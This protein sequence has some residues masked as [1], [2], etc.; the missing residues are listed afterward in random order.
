[1]DQRKVILG[2]LLFSV[3]S[4]YGQNKQPSLIEI[5]K[6]FIGKPYRGQ[7]LSLGNPEQ[8]ITSQEA[9]DCVTFLEHCLATRIAAGDSNA[10]IPALKHVRYAD[11]SVK[12]ENRYHYFSDAMWHLEY[13]LIQDPLHHATVA[14]DFSFLSNYWR[15]QKASSV[16]INLLAQ[17]EAELR[18]RTF[19]Y[20]AL[21]DLPYVL[22]LIRD[23]DLIAL[24]GRKNYLD[25]LHTS[26]AVLQGKHIYLLHASQ[27]NK[28]VEI[29]KQ[30]LSD[31]L[32]THKQFIGI[33]IFRPIFKG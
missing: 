14:K 32:K 9:F 30:T 15:G 25:F 12:Y 24:V 18:Q 3:F 27:E 21:S 1:M 28:K 2:V 31:Y 22:P 29:S 7:M 20:T 10:F 23:G 6:Q 4:L 17:R 8:L 13:Q 11:D 33:C 5:G 19:E 16:D 26:M